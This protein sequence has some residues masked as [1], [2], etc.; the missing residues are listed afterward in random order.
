VTGPVII[1]KGP[2]IIGKAKYF[3]YEMKIIDKCR[4]SGS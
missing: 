4:F 1:E 2:V 3:Y